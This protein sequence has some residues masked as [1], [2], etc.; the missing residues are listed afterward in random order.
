[1]QA[2]VMPHGTR[3]ACSNAHHKPSCNQQ[4]CELAKPSEGAAVERCQLVFIEPSTKI[5]GT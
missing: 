4:C 1:M 3:E 2:G 5:A